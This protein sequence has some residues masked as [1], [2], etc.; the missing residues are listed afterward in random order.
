MKISFENILIAA[1]YILA[2]IYALSTSG[3]ALAKLDIKIPGL[4]Q[5]GIL[6]SNKLYGRV[7]SSN[8]GEEMSNRKKVVRYAIFWLFIGLVALA[9]GVF[10]LFVS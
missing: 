1:I 10:L 7:K 2:G 6:I 8:F 4:Y 3:L 5:L 9:G